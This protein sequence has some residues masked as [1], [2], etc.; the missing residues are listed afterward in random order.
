M[1]PKRSAVSTMSSLPISGPSGAKSALH[2]SAK[3]SRKV[4][5]QNSPLALLM[6]RPPTLT[7]STISN[8]SSSETTPFCRAAVVVIVLKVDP[9]GCGAEKA[10]PAR[11]RTSPLRA[12]STATPPARPARA[13]TGGELQVGVDRRLHRRPRP[14][15]GLG[16]DTGRAGAVFDREQ[17]A[18]GPAGE[19][20]VEG[21][22]EA[23]DADRGT[24]R[25]ALPGE[26]REVFFLGFADFAGDV[27]RGAADRVF[28]SFGGAFGERRPVA[29]EDRRAQRQ[30][31]SVFE[32]LAGLEAGEEKARTPG[33]AAVGV[34]ELEIGGDVA[35]GDRACHDGTGITLRAFHPVRSPAEPTSNERRGATSAAS[36]SA[37]RTQPHRSGGETLRSAPGT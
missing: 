4:P 30:V 18:A 15:F 7:P 20:R 36:W 28:A 1:K 14:G 12:S 34:G 22:L 31:D 13:D 5:P 32:V 23:A 21:L 6:K 35:E 25:E 8:S 2:D 27:D 26:R 19:A 11:A 33:D 24:G 9:G 16:E 29:G 3:A 17:R 10:C 37:V